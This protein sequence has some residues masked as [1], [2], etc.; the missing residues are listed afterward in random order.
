MS[1]VIALLLQKDIYAFI[2][3]ESDTIDAQEEAVDEKEPMS[4]QEVLNYVAEFDEYDMS[5]DEDNEYA[6]YQPSW[7]LYKFP[8]GCAGKYIWKLL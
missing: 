6:T 3:M 5:I 7:D 2:E 1:F 4:I 8:Y